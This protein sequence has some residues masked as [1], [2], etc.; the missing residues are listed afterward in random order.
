MFSA[1]AQ[2]D[3]LAS[4]TSGVINDKNAKFQGIVKVPIEDLVFAPDLTAC[5]HNV[6]LAKVSRLKRIF[7]TEGCNR[8]DPSNFIV[9]NISQEMLSEAMRLSN[10][11]SEDL[12]ARGEPRMLYL[13]RF[14]YIKCAKGRSRAKALLD[15]PCFGLWWTVELYI[16]KSLLLL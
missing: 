5:D 16:G 9:G 4:L 10:L 6:N 2:A 3:R 14:Q 12:R 13:P 8:S 15:T 1:Q 11:T 7:K